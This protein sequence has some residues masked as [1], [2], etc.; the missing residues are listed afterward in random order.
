MRSK[1]RCVFDTNCLISALL[2]RTS[3]SRAAFDKALEHHQILVSS[4]TMA[5]FDD[6]AGREK[7]DSYLT[8]EEREG[9]EERLHREAR[10]VEVTDAVEAS[11]DPD[12]DMFLSLAVSGEADY[13]V[14]GDEDLRTLDPF[15]GIRIVSPATFVEDV[16]PV[17]PE[18][19]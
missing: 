14:S 4:E 2:I 17:E 5:E 6:V 15:D 12:D 19:S 3:I 11:R 9:F 8:A 16:P 13:L 1:L 7:F 10:F 18:S